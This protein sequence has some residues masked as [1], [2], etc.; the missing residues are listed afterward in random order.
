MSGCLP[1]GDQC[2]L[3]RG[4]TVGNVVLSE[5]KNKDK[6]NISKYVA[7]F[8]PPRRATVYEV[9]DCLIT[10]GQRKC[11]FLIL[12][13][14]R[15]AAYFIELKN[16]DLSAAI[17]QLN[18]SLDLL[19]PKLKSTMPDVRVHAR[20]VLSRVNRADLRDSK[21]VAFQKKIDSLGGTLKQQSQKF[22][23]RME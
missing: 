21:Y 2:I 17:S 10:E 7:Q 5:K 16:P 23:D 3:R 6:K 8:V 18:S 13:C 14:D 4:E 12:D 19:L 20:I 11:D 9:D 15:K 1:L 22:I